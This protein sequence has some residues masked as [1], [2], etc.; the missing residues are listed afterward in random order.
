M[1]RTN[2][3]EILTLMSVTFANVSL[4]VVGVIVTLSSFVH[5]GKGLLVAASVGGILMVKG[6]SR[7][8]LPNTLMV[9]GVVAG[10]LTLVINFNA[11][12]GVL[13]KSLAALV[14]VLLGVIVISKWLFRSLRETG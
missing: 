1:A 14:L 8:A 7:K 12:T 3:G 13:A 11:V 9:L 6:A 2:E 4:F 5:G 10:L